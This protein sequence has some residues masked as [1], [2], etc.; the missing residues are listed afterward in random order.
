MNRRIEIAHRRLGVIDDQRDVVAPVRL[1]E[2]RN[3]D[4]P[5]CSA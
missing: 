3:T 4:G 2:S 1:V 5:S